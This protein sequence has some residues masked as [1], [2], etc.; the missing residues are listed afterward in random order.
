MEAVLEICKSLKSKN[1]S[2]LSQV[3]KASQQN[4]KDQI[5]GFTGGVKNS[6]KLCQPPREDGDTFKSVYKVSHLRTTQSYTSMQR[7]QG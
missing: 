3:F 1:M 2:R 6:F 7:K 4:P 5:N